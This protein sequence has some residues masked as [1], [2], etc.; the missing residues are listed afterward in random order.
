MAKKHNEPILDMTHVPI[1]FADQAAGL[2][3]GAHVSRLT[4]GVQEDDGTDYPR[5][6][7]TIAIPTTSLLDLVSDLRLI[8]EDDDFRGDVNQQLESSARKLLAGVRTARSPHLLETNIKKKP[9]DP[10]GPPSK[11]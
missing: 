7:V 2:A 1:F 8:F 11:D 4:F 9:K 3:V 6:V 10:K 5:P